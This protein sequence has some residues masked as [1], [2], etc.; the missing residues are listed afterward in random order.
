MRPSDPIP[1]GSAARMVPHSEHD[2]ARA[3]RLDA[4]LDPHPSPDPVS[5]AE[6]RAAGTTTP[7]AT[8]GHGAPILLLCSPVGSDR[9]PLIAALAATGRVVAPFRRPPPPDGRPPTWLVP[10]L[11]G[12]GLRSVIV[13]GVGTWTDA[14]LRFAAAEPE[15]TGRLVLVD[16]DP[17]SALLDGLRRNGVPV[18]RVVESDLPATDPRTWAPLAALVVASADP[19]GG[20][21]S[22]SDRGH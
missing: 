6:V 21:R 1:V 8:A 5:Y 22:V 4:P 2:M 15:R 11:D 20:D 10:F 9:A 13:V 12:L 18:D 3:R 19:A 14:A 16:A 17:P 7:Y